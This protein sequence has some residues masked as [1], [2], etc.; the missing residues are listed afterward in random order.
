MSEENNQHQGKPVALPERKDPTQHWVEP[1]GVHKAEG[2][3]ACLDEIAKLGPLYTYTDPVALQRA[4]QAGYDTAWYSKNPADKRTS[5]NP[6][7]PGEVERLRNCLRTEIEAGDSWK[8][9]AE[10]LR[11]QLAEL[12]KQRIRLRDN[13]VEVLKE[14]MALQQKLVERD[15]LLRDWVNSD[16][17]MGKECSVEGTKDACRRYDDALVRARDAL[18]ASAEPRTENK[19]IKTHDGQKLLVQHILDTDKGLSENSRKILEEL[20]K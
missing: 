20:I 1:G 6:Y 3:N 4:W 8:K 13:N 2:W 9:E 5:V 17:D 14:N 10:D 19:G 16:D 12:E 7:D 15:A 18:S 11:T